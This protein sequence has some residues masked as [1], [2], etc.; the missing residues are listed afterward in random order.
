MK[1]EFF[2]FS[3]SFPEPA[4]DTY[5][6]VA[7]GHS[8]GV[9][10]DYNDV[11]EHVSQLINQSITDFFRFFTDQ[12]LPPTSPQK[13]VNSGWS[14]RVFPQVLWWKSGRWVEIHRKN[15]SRHGN[16]KI[17]FL[18]S[19][20]R[21]KTG[22]KTRIETQGR[23]GGKRGEEEKK[24]VNTN[25]GFSLKF[26][27]ILPQSI[28]WLYDL[29]PENWSDFYF[30]NFQVFQNFL[31]SEMIIFPFFQLFFPI[32]NYLIF[33]I[34][35]AFCHLNICVRGAQKWEKPISSMLWPG[36]VR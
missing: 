7:R 3:V 34:F 25:F 24:E 32:S 27:I 23:Q 28:N 5:Y 12:K 15:W 29:S 33:P 31:G 26:R 10:T 35:N 6:A 13:M 8:V 4:H 36:D 16:L 22:W 20:K 14:S 2:S 11:K 30:F 9:F 17:L 1:T 18:T 21:R 19:R